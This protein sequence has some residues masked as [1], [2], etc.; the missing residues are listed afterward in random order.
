VGRGPV[1]DPQGSVRCLR[2]FGVTATTAADQ[3]KVDLPLLE[4]S[5]VGRVPVHRR[6]V[7]GDV[8]GVGLHGHWLGELNLLPAA[9]GLV[10]EGGV[11][12]QRPGRRPQAAHMGG[13]RRS[14]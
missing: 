9:G 14:S 10:G 2:Y 1:G 13:L 7:R 6:V 12:Q 5:R 8:D 3:E 11:G 4:V